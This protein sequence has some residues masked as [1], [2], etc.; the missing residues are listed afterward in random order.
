[1]S[2]FLLQVPSNMALLLTLE[3]RVEQPSWFKLRAFEIAANALIAKPLPCK[4]L[5]DWSYKNLNLK[6]II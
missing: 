6:E 1:M 2:L 5:M 3:Q 4:G